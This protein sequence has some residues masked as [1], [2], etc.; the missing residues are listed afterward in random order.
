MIRLSRFE[1][2]S[3]G[4][5]GLINLNLFIRF[6]IRIGYCPINVAA[7]IWIQNGINQ[8]VSKYWLALMF[9]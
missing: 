8:S 1:I 5:M 3:I 7:V 6:F 4:Y 2:Q 9:D